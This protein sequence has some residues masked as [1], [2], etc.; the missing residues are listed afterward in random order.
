MRCVG[1]TRA[2]RGTPSEL[3][4]EE[5]ALPLHLEGGE[6]VAL[7]GEHP[8][9]DG[10]RKLADMAKERAPVREGRE[11]PLEAPKHTLVAQR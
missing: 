8:R 5:R 2:L 7:K 3:R 11:Q 4:R 1:S 9:E 10:G 6:V